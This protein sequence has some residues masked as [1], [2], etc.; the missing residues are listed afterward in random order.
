MI[1][2]QI[3]PSKNSIYT[4]VFFIITLHCV[5]IRKVSLVIGYL[6][7]SSDGLSGRFCDYYYF[8]P[9][10][11][12]FDGQMAQGELFVNKSI[13]MGFFFQFNTILTGIAIIYIAIIG[14]YKSY[15][16]EK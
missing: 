3:L 13:S 2:S 7:M 10:F 16:F 5:C 15:I 1:L 4:C 12:A 14:L 6:Y 9:D 8:F 11:V